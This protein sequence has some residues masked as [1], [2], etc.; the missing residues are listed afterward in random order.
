MRLSKRD[1]PTH[2]YM[3]ESKDCDDEQT[4]LSE[5]C[6]N[7][8]AN[9]RT[10][11]TYNAMTRNS[12]KVLGEDLPD[13][14]DEGEY[15]TRGQPDVAHVRRGKSPEVRESKFGLW[16]MLHLMST[17]RQVDQVTHVPEEPAH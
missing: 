7:P 1:R 4:R 16:H 17:A 10:G 2:T 8:Q 6:R 12:T 14:D 3:S 11:I 13:E 9:C 5:C 15:V